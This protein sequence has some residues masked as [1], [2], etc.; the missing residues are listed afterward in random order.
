MYMLVMR[1]WFDLWIVISVCALS[2]MYFS[3]ALHA[4]RFTLCVAATPWCVMY[5]CI[6]SKLCVFAC[7]FLLC[8]ACP[9]CI[10][11][12]YVVVNPVGVPRPPLLVC[13]LLFEQTCYHP[14]FTC[15]DAPRR[16]VVWIFL[17][18]EELRGV[19]YSVFLPFLTFGVCT[20]V[21]WYDVVVFFYN[22]VSV[23]IQ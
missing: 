1:V 18:W 6:C 10:C 11:S 16:W 3:C 13:R 8:A 14:G 2:F 20:C 4:H 23:V 17:W 9:V 12:F 7:F 15:A 5:A 21:S 22:G 19:C